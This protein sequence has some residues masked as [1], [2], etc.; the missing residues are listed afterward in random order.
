M[1]NTQPTQITMKDKKVCGL[2]FVHDG[3]EEEVRAPLII[4]DPSYALTCNSGELKGK[5]RMVGKVIRAICILDHAIPNTNN[6]TS[7]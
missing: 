4:C 3:N 6:S 5:V 1:L 7:C 2:K